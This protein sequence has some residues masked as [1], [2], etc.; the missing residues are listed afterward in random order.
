MLAPGKSAFADGRGSGLAA[1][2]PPRRLDER[3]IG[4]ELVGDAGD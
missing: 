2:L 4:E 3:R 1:E